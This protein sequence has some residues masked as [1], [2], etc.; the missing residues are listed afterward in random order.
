[1]STKQS[2][3]IVGAGPR[4]SFALARKF[5]EGLG[6]VA[7]ISRTADRLATLVEELNGLGVAGHGFVADAADLNAL[8]AAIRKATAA[9]SPLK[10]LIYNAAIVRP[11]RPLELDPANLVNELIV[12]A[13]APLAA[14]QIVTPVLEANGGGSVLFTGG[15]FGTS[16]SAEMAAL[17]AGKAALRNLTA[18][19]AQDLEPKGIRTAVVTI[20]DF[21]ADKGRFGADAVAESFWELHTSR[22]G[23][24]GFEL[25]YA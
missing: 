24:R 20:S 19:L 5:G 9:M 23:E 11:C 15:W 13:V 17:S 22:S 10:V 1:M 25:T 2:A 6:E 12:D 7:L 21:L 8:G 4:L 16:P 14:A 18:T 3:I